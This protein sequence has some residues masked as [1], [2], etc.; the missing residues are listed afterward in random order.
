MFMFTQFGQS[1]SR[2]AVIDTVHR[3][4]ATTNVIEMFEL[5]MHII[6]KLL[7]CISQGTVETFYSAVYKLVAGQ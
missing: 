5:L 3:F 2:G 1:L 7:F 4:N 6:E